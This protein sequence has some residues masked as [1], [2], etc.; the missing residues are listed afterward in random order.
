MIPTWIE[1][2]IPVES[3][4]VTVYVPELAAEGIPVKY[5]FPEASTVVND[6]PAGRLGARMDVIGCDPVPK[7]TLALNKY[8]D[9]VGTERPTVSV[10]R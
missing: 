3:V 10:G 4:A 2:T 9:V 7:A 8:A 5:E 6:N 1:P